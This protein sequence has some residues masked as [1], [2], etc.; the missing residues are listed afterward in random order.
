M[1]ATNNVNPD[2]FSWNP[3]PAEIESSRITTA[4]KFKVMNP[5][6]MTYT[7]DYEQKEIKWFLRDLSVEEWDALFNEKDELYRR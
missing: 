2:L 5:Q 1:T 3:T 4:Q 7:V 6:D